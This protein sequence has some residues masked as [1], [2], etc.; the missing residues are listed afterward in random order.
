MYQLA[1]TQTFSFYD[2]DYTVVVVLSSCCIKLFFIGIQKMLCRL[3]TTTENKREGKYE[4]FCNILFLNFQRKKKSAFVK[5]G[6][7]FRQDVTMQTRLASELQS[8]F[9]SY[10]GSRNS[11]MHHHLRLINPLLNKE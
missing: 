5:G 4:K 6:I 1:P 3:G 9:L 10:L 8:S 11:G 7:H 2:V